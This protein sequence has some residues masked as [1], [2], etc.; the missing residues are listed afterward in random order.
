MTIL[1]GWL[2]MPRNIEENIKVVGLIPFWFDNKNGIDLKK[3][4]GKYLIEYTAELL[5]SS[6]LIQETVIYSSNE[7]IMEYISEELDVKHLNRPESLDGGEILIE[8]IISQFL[9]DYDYDFDILV[10]MHP[11]CPFIR[12]S[13]IDECINSI[14]TGKNDSAFTA[15]EFQRFSWFKGKPL[16]FNVEQFSPKLKSLESITIEQ[17]LTYA[18]SK[19]SFIENKSRIGVNPLAKIINHFE[20]HEI[21]DADDYEMAELIVNS[22]MYKGP[23]NE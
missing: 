23:F 9:N 14:K 17:G 1:R 7:K 15:L 3:V 21:K 18:L 8:E 20:G 11:F 12:K 10:L 5:N 16:N 2:N 13:T 22:G 19:D 4:A 6:S